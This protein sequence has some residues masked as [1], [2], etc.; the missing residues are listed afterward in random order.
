MLGNFQLIEQLT[1][2]MLD[3]LCKGFTELVEVFLVEENLV[4]LVLILTDALAL[5][6]G[7]VKV[8]L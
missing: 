4:L 6:N 7:D 5:G 3:S 8:L 1:L 2:H